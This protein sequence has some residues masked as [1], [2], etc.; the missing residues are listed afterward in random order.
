[1]SC[2]NYIVEV[3]AVGLGIFVMRYRYEIVVPLDSYQ[4]S[5]KYLTGLHSSLDMYTGIRLSAYGGI[6]PSVRV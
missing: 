1:M 3:I 5:E 6:N 2:N 4:C